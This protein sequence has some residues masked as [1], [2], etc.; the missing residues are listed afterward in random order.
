M[1]EYAKDTKVTVEKSRAEIETV[2]RKYNATD[3][4][5][6]WAGNFAKIGF[7]INGRSIRFTLPLPDPKDRAYTK[8]TRYPYDRTP[9][10]ATAMWEQ[11]CRQRWRALLLTI[12]AKLEAV[13]CKIEEFD[14]AF[15]AH[16]VMPDGMTIGE[17][18]LPEIKSFLV[19]GQMPLMLT[20]QTR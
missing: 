17:K 19:T 14:E 10:Q 8:T 2:L 16:I 9:S 6:G 1:P 15:M 18:L 3:F 13:D 5:S 12:K 7:T 4:A 11:A 20:D